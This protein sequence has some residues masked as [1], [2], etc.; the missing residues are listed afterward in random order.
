MPIAKPKIPTAIPGTNNFLL[1]IAAATG[2]INGGLITPAAD[3]MMNVSK[4]IL[5]ILDRIKCK[6]ND[7]NAIQNVKK[8]K[9]GEM[10]IILV[11][12]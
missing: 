2:G 8:N 1:P 11:R 10:C 4:S 5:K 3:V 9:I 6:K 12:Q 7:P